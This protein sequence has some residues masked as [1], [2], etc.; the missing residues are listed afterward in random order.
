MEGDTPLHSAVRYVNQL[1]RNAETEE[2]AK[3][4]IGMM[5]EAG[6]D[7]RFVPFLF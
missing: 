3:E 7:P 4:L 2:Y 1:P 5:C 6:S